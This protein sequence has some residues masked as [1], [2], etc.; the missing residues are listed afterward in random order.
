MLFLKVQMPITRLKVLP[1]EIFVWWCQDDQ[2]DWPYN[3]FEIQPNA[4]NELFASL[5]LEQWAQ[6]NAKCMPSAKGALGYIR[7]GSAE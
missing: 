4:R 2:A 6:R 3:I 1:L 7:G 5:P